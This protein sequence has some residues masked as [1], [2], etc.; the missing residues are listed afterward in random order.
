MRSA[1]LALGA[2][3][4]SGVGTGLGGA[5]VAGE[6]VE[7]PF[8]PLFRDRVHVRLGVQRERPMWPFWGQLRDVQLVSHRRQATAPPSRPSSA[9]AT[10]IRTESSKPLR[11]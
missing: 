9:R 3:S 10:T 8:I 1:A 7:R 4:E 11:A 6:R 5:C 2:G